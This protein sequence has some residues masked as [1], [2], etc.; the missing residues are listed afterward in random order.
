MK[1]IDTFTEATEYLNEAEPAL[2]T[3]KAVYRCSYCLEIIPHWGHAPA[4]ALIYSFK[5]GE[6]DVV[7]DKCPSPLKPYQD[8]K[9]SFHVSNAQN[10]YRLK[11]RISYYESKNKISVLDKVALMELAHFIGDRPEV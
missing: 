3:T 6:W 7:C 2:Y 5:E 10:Y 8:F 11:N 4:L 9:I 1:R